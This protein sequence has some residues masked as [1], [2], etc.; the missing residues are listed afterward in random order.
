MMLLS[1]DIT[2]NY[3]ATTAILV[4]TCSSN[5]IY[6]AV[7]YC[8]HVTI[9]YGSNYICIR[10]SNYLYSSYFLEQCLQQCSQSSATTAMPMETMHAVIFQLCTTYSNSVCSYSA[11]VHMQMP[12]R[13]AMLLTVAI[14]LQQCYYLQQ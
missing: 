11:Q 10:H 14:S 7:V 8:S 2:T 1:S 3:L 9:T 4:I 5:V 6:A 12:L 13:G